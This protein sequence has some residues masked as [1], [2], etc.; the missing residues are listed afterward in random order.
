MGTPIADPRKKAIKIHWYSTTS[1]RN[2]V[3]T[4]ASSIPISPTIIPRR[5][6][7]GEFIHL[8]A[9]MND[10]AAS[11]YRNGRSVSSSFISLPAVSFL[12]RLPF[13]EHLQHAV[14]DEIAADFVEGRQQRRREAQNA[15]QRARVLCSGDQDRADDRDG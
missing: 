1:N 7:A 6:V 9:R 14:G 2:N 13:L 8:M 11:M 4:T 3:P 12:L 10:M 5:A 15:R